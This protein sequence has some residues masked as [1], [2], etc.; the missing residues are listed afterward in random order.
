MKNFLSSCKKSFI[1]TNKK[2]SF[3]HDIINNQLV[4]FQLLSYEED[5]RSVQNELKDLKEEYD[6]EIGILQSQIKTLK[7]EVKYHLK[8]LFP[9]K[10]KK[11]LAYLISAQ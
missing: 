6:K 7:K 10:K 9:S 4:F 8:W 1:Y 5:Y 11:D 2:D 3:L